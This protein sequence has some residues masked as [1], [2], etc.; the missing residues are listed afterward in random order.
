[1]PK[2]IVLTGGKVYQQ[3][4]LERIERWIELLEQRVNDLLYTQQPGSKQ[5][6]R[7]L[8][9]NRYIILL[10]HLLDAR[11]KCADALN[12]VDRQHIF[13]MITQGKALPAMEEKLRDDFEESF[14]S[15]MSEALDG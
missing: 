13:D 7:D 3:D 1:M 2:Q 9:I 5:S 15:W 6:E 14:S 11:Q 10:A 8:A 12:V 4:G